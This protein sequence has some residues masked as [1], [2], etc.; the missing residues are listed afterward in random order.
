M[1][2]VEGYDEYRDISMTDNHLFLALTLL[3][4]GDEEFTAGALAST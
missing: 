3:S 1:P 2:T 4:L